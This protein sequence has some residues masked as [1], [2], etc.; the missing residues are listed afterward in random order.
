MGSSVLDIPERG[1][2]TAWLF[3]GDEQLWSQIY[4]LA[5]DQVTRIGR[6]PDNEIVLTDTRCSRHH[7]EVFLDDGRWVVRDC[8][9]R[10]GTFLGTTRVAQ[11]ES[12]NDWD[13]IHVGPHT[14][15]FTTDPD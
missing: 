1:T 12:L 15:V 4:R 6:G 9:S 13:V 3:V 2:A 11:T 5:P 10:N 14:L 7:C 8:E